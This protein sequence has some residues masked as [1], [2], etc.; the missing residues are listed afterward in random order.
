MPHSHIS[1][2]FSLCCLVALVGNHP[3]AEVSFFT[4]SLALCSNRA[5]LV[6]GLGMWDGK[7]LAFP[8][9]LE[10][11]PSRNTPSKLILG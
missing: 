8:G 11:P 4:L 3:R 9:S 5:G 7:V 1:A 2:L 6:L 10:K